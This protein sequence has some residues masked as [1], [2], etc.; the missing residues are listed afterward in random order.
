VWV[1]ELKNFVGGFHFLMRKG[2]M[3]KLKWGNRGLDDSDLTI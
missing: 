3:V 1:L 2:S